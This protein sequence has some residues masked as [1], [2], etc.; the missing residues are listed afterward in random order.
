MGNISSTRSLLVVFKSLLEAKGLELKESTL[1]KFLWA[2]DEVAP[3]FAVS[4]HLTLPSS[5]KLGKD[6]D[7][8]RE[9]GIVLPG[10]QSIWKLVHS[11]LVDGEGECAAEIERGSAALEQ[12]KEERSV[13]LEKVT[14]LIVLRMMSWKS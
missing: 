13:K 9:Q 4:G 10:T 12:V 1:E 8:A 11:C 14:A 3:W 5:D 6:I 7:F 2:V